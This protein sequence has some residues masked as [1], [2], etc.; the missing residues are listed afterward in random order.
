ML[1]IP[2]DLFARAERLARKTKK[3][4][5]R[6]FIDVLKEYLASNESDRVTEAMNSALVEVGKIDDHFVSVL[7]QRILKRSEW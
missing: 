1:S 4:R 7:A 5:S 2:D 3:S 6:L